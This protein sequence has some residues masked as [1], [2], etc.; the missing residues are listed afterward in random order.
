MYMHH[1]RI[2]SNELRHEYGIPNGEEQRDADEE[3]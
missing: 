3:R 2:V 1:L